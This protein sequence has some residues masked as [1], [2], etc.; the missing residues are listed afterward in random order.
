M[1]RLGHLPQVRQLSDSLGWEARAVWFQNSV[2]SPTQV[3]TV[4]YMVHQ[5]LW[6]AGRSL[7]SPQGLG[8]V[9]LLF[10]SHP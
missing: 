10:H 3:P 7:I 9:F 4:P 1:E 8:Q 2:S 6:E 5:A